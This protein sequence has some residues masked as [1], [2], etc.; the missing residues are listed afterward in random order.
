MN[1]F[2]V[3]LALVM[4]AALPLPPAGAAAAEP[5]ATDPAKVEAQLKALEAEIAKFKE[6]LKST[7]TERSK[8][9]DTLESNEKQI[10]ELLKK[11]EAIQ[12]DLKSG[13]D[14]VSSLRGEQRSLEDAKGKQ[15]TLIAKQVRA[16]YEI[17]SEEYLKVVLNQEDPNRLAR[18]LAYYDYFNRARADQ[19]AQFKTT[20]AK[21]EDVKQAIIAENRVLT[22]KRAVLADEKT[23]LE[24]VRT[25]KTQTLALLKQE[26]KRTGSELQIRTRDRERLEALLERITAGIVNLPTPQ[27]TLPFGDRRG[28]LLYPVAGTITDRFGSPRNDGKLRWNG[29]FIAAA[30]GD[31]VKAIHYGRVVFSDWLRGFGLLLIINHGDGYMSLYGHNQVLYR[32]TGDWVTAGETIATVGDSGGQN[33]PGLYFEIRHAGKPTDPQQWCQARPPRHA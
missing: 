28:K 13:E 14:K 11:I 23:S 15:E 18:M 4:L 2:T 1:R 17:G 29:V 10:G 8:L 22:E 6:M 16:A 20:I 19:I 24:S 30:P 25:E 7:E 33:R 9:E 21:L 3:F 32:E 27:D 31:P 26:I 5:A 12:K